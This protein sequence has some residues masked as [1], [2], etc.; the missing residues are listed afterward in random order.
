M[1]SLRPQDDVAI[2]NA[3]IQRWLGSIVDAKEVDIAMHL[4]NARNK[5]AFSATL[6]LIMLPTPYSPHFFYPPISVNASDR[7][8]SFD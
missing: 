6:A 7:P 3:S 4:K 5:E 1:Q 8:S 2:D